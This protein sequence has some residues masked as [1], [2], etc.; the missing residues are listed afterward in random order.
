MDEAMLKRVK[1]IVSSMAA[2]GMPRE[3]IRSTLLQMGVPP[4]DAETL[5]QE[6]KPEVTVQEV[7]AKAEATRTM[8]ETGQH[9]KPAL[10]KLEEQEEHFERLHTSVGE[11]HGRQASVESRLSEVAEIKRDVSEIRQE[12]SEIKPMISALKRLNDNLLEINRKM[13]AELGAR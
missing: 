1:D 12:L 5:L 8:L 10:Q 3:E 2:Q 6:A 11:L 9:L 4:Q 13:L 7:G